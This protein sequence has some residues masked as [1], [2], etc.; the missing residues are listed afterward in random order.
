MFDTATRVPPH[1]FEAE[2]ALLGAILLSNRTYEKVSEFL[3]PE[4]FADPVHGRI[5]AACG[6]LIERGQMANPVTL[7]PYFELDG[8]LAEI[9]GMA[10]LA[11]LANSVVSTANAADYGR[12]ILDLHQRRELI[13]LGEDMINRAFSP[14]LESPAGELIEEAEAALSALAEHGEVGGGARDLAAV[15]PAMVKESDAARQRGGKGIGLASGL[16]DLDDRLGGLAPG[17][18]VVLGARPAMG[19]SALAICIARHVAATQ[20]PVGAFSLEMRAEEIGQRLASDAS[21]IPYDAIRSGAMTD[22]EWGRM[23]QAEHQLADLPVR[24]DDTAGLTIG[25]IHAR[26][27]RMRRRHGIGLLVVDHLH[28][29]RC[30]GD[31]R[32][33]ELTRISA[34]LKEIARELGIPVLALCQLNRSVEQRDD[35]RPQLADLRES[36][37]IEQDADAVVFLF[38]A[39]YYLENSEPSRKAGEGDTA[40]MGRLAD[41]NDDVRRER[42]RAELI[43]AKNR[44]GR[45][46]TVNLYADLALSRFRSLAHACDGGR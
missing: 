18:L 27:R 28:L 19:K 10:Y 31:N 25:Q 11:Q 7:K 44:H 42:N 39:G 13:G 20:A 30:R 3:R 14:D 35:K 41:W 17:N 32:L 15:M 46:G 45:T 9:G 37:T 29:I 1:N 40:Y 16:V 21:D 6:K 36:G 26:A 8:G 2:Q 12:L 34:G 43:I 38:R 4:H 23:R 33:A 24:I 22:E 5:F